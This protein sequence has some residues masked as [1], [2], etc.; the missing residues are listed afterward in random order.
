MARR[1][2]TVFTSYVKT[3]S[4]ARTNAKYIGF[5]DRKNE[6]DTYGVFSKD[7]DHADIKKFS[8]ELDTKMTRHSSVAV[9]HK[10]L[11]TMSQDEWDR[12][13][14]VMGDYKNM[15]RTALRDYEI[16]TGK[17]L[18]W[19]ASEHH[20]PG[21]PH[22]HVL[23][24]ATYHDR[25]GVEKRLMIRP[26][27]RDMIRGYFQDAKNYIRGF[28]VEPPHEKEYK[29]T[30]DNE[31]SKQN[32]LNRS[33]NAAKEHIFNQLKQTLDRTEFER[34]MERTKEQ[35]GYDRGR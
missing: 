21:H 29:R 24:K 4:D 10:F 32:E 25:D 35:R 7:N 12:S 11:F 22:V 17:R 28:E 14:F 1:L 2:G 19:I 8:K 6:R 9:A 15:V 34:E 23:I 16:N 30:Y 20:D 13:G 18:T 33:L 31:H 3:L 27:D 26:E 5:R